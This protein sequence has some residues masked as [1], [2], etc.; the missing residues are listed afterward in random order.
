MTMILK[1]SKTVTNCPY[2]TYNGTV[3]IHNIQSRKGF[4]LLEAMMAMVLLAI[5]AAG[6]LLP[7]AG[8][9]NQQAQGAH[10]TIAAQ[11]ASELMERIAA[12]DFSTIIATY[13]G[14]AESA[15]ALR[16]AAGQMHTGPAYAGFSRY[17][18]CQP[19]TAASV[20]MV[21]VTVVVL[22]QGAEITR[23]TTLVGRN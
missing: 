4:T 19:A 2:S 7:F 1:S 3:L 17:A 5:A 6:V 10:Q 21:Q 16:D 9:A 23:A 22:Y 13:N 12:A 8:A 18:V 14:Y 11:L 15:G 20:N